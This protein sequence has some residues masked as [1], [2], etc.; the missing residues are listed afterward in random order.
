MKRLSFASGITRIASIKASSAASKISFSFFLAITFPLSREGIGRATYAPVSRFE[1]LAKAHPTLSDLRPDELPPAAITLGL[2]RR[3]AGRNGLA[4]LEATDAGGNLLRLQNPKLRIIPEVLERL[5]ATVG[6]TGLAVRLGGLCVGLAV[7]TLDHRLIA[8]RLCDKLRLGRLGTRRVS[9]RGRHSV[10]PPC[11]N[12]TPRRLIRLGAYS[13]L[14]CQTTNSR[15]M[16]HF[17]TKEKRKVPLIS[18]F[19]NVDFGTF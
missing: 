5:A 13:Y 16:P 8:M 3:E 15:M 14:Q 18:R 6:L 12:R 17:V 10:S 2:L 19:L 1:G 7:R 11:R 9:F 4:G